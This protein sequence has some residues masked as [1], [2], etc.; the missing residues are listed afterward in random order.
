MARF[1][2]WNSNRTK[3]LIETKAYGGGA[4]IWRQ[5]S[6]KLFAPSVTLDEFQGTIPEM[7]K[8]NGFD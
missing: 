2:Y 4:D 5:F 3:N 7:R 6:D 1:L 8:S